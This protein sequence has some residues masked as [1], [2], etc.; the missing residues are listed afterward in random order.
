MTSFILGADVAA[1]APTR[2]E[3]L[4][5]WFSVI[6]GGAMLWLGASI[7]ALG[8]LGRR[9]AAVSVEETP[10]RDPCPLAVTIL[11]SAGT[12]ALGRS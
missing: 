3:E 12:S 8:A 1:I 7:W 11:D 10:E 6:A 5:V 2:R 9:E 4:M